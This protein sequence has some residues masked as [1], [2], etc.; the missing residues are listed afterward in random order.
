MDKILRCEALMKTNVRT[1]SCY[2]EDHDVST[3]LGA[4]SC[5][6]QHTACRLY[7]KQNAGS[8]HVLAHEVGFS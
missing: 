6:S 2:R 7:A 3:V 8:I 1:E 4:I 5:R